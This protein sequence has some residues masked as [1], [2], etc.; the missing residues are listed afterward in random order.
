VQGLNVG[1]PG[2]LGRPG[3]CAIGAGGNWCAG[4]GHAPSRAHGRWQAGPGS[5]AL[6][7]SATRS[8]GHRYVPQLGEAARRLAAQAGNA[9][10]TRGVGWHGVRVFLRARRAPA[11][12]TLPGVCC[13]VAQALTSRLSSTPS[14]RLP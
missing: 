10:S 11:A 7:A 8:L 1:W 6:R 2:R 5:R 13:A 9:T 3:R 14:S 12:L 4:L